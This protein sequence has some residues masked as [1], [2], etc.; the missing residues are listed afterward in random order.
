MI[1]RMAVVIDLLERPLYG[2]GQVDRIL[3]LRGGTARRWI[4][5]YSRGGKD[6]RR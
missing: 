5:G 4:D 6:T 2:L 1:S 3:G